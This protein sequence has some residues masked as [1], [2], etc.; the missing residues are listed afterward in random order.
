MDLNKNKTN[1][2]LDDILNLKPKE[3]IKIE[4][5][6][7]E[8]SIFEDLEIINF[9]NIPTEFSTNNIIVDITLNNLNTPF[10]LTYDKDH[11]DTI[12]KD[13]SYIFESKYIGE[14]VYKYSL[15]KYKVYPG[16]KIKINDKLAVISDFTID[17]KDSLISNL[18]YIPLKKDG[19]VSKVRPRLIYGGSNWEKV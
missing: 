4:H 12:I 10:T 8:I 2:T 7:M 14:I 15:C 17:Y 9:L 19:T 11:P 6:I 18:R 13:V 3:I 5:D 16:C 1:L